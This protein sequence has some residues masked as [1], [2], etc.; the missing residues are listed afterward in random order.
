ME[1]FVTK[2]ITSQSCSYN[3]F[4]KFL[5]FT[6]IITPIL[7]SVGTFIIINCPL[8]RDTER[9]PRPFCVKLL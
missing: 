5:Y 1:D 9:V 2:R 4:K 3:S 8:I 6:F 7:L